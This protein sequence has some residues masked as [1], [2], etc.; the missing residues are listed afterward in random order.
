MLK[1]VLEKQR[2]ERGDTLIEVTFALAILGF[3]LLS[4]TAVASTAFRIG[5]TAKERTQVAD[6]AQRQME[7]LRSFR[8]NHTWADFRQGQ[9]GVFPGIDTVGGTCSFDATKQCFFMGTQP[10]TLGTQEFVPMPGST[11]ANVPTS[12]IEIENAT[13]LGI[14][15]QCGYDFVLHYSFH[16]LGGGN[17][18]DVDASNQ[19]AT[20]LVDLHYSPPPGGVCP[21]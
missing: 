18:G 13:P 5:Q 10:T 15:R 8:D 1:L 16:T 19:I 21:P 2:S 12:I 11:S 6:A 14:I 4:S 3:V 20:R 17:T 7:A 9:A